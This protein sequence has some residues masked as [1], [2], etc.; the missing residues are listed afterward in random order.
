MIRGVLNRLAERL[1]PNDPLNAALSAA[2]LKEN[3]ETVVESL[4]THLAGASADRVHR[5]ILSWNERREFARGDTDYLDDRAYRLLLA[6]D[7]GAAVTPIPAADRARFEQEARL[8]HLPLTD[9]FAELAE[10]EPR[11]KRARGTQRQGQAPSD[12]RR[13]TTPGTRIRTCGPR[14]VERHSPADR[15]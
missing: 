9:A 2:K 4:R 1:E 14:S 15:L 8:G 10:A 3:D 13:S 6:V 5:T 11:P 12:Q 7:Q